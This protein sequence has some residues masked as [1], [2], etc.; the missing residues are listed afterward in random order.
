MAEL[1]QNFTVTI[2]GGLHARP[3]SELVGIAKSFHSKIEILRDGKV[4]N[5]KSPVKILLLGVR[6]GDSITVMIDG[7]DAA[8]AMARVST[9]FEA[10]DNEN[11]PPAAEGGAAAKPTAPITIEAAKAATP[12]HGIGASEGA[13]EGVAYHFFQSPL[14]DPSSLPALEVKGNSKEQELAR[15]RN[16]LARSS[17]EINARAK[18][19]DPTGA[20]I[21]A[22]LSEI[23]G[24]EEW[25]EQV[26]AHI[27]AGACALKAVLI[28]GEETARSVEALDDPYA[29]ARAEDIRAVMRII[30]FTLMG[31]EL[32][33]LDRVPYG[34][35]VVA[36]E[37]TALDLST[38]D[39]SRI[40]GLLCQKGASTSHAAIVSRAHGIPA[41]F[42]FEVSAAK[43]QRVSYVALDGSSGEVVLDPSEEVIARYRA[44]ID[45]ERQIA[46][47]RLA[48]KEVQPVT[49]DGREITIAANIGSL[50]EIKAAKENGA[51]GVGL[52]RTELLFMDR[53]EL[54]TEDEQLAIY[55]VALRAFEGQD[56]IIRT[57]DIGGD[58]PLRGVEFPAEENP[59]LGW[60]GIRMCLD[61]PSI[62][63]PQ[64]R[65]LLR[66][67]PAGKLKV[68]LPMVSD[69]E[70]VRATKQLI[71]ECI[72]E[73]DAEGKPY[74]RF[75]LGIMVETPAAVLAAELFAKE[76]AFFSIGTNDL[77]QYVMAADRMNPTVAKLY[78]TDNAAVLNAVS[79]VCLAAQSAGIWV[80]VCGE[81][82]ANPD[83]ARKFIERGVTELSMSPASI[84]RAKQVVCEL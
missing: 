61:T 8:D 5:A 17:D 81:A 73:L 72:M 84:L 82:A 34:A 38:A 44:S 7:D 68:M 13:A 24:D 1:Q 16:A 65:A 23:A 25:Q 62:F 60:R 43:L 59:F 33:S 80:G 30:A 71:D 56:V 26:T 35:I 50:G 47:Q 14:P 32:P 69:I 77:T 28:S 48:F 10:G 40:G 12:T 75:D 63:K 2:H 29:R 45:A 27:R 46:K 51:M 18:D 42:G 41:V 66:A 4:A 22:A 3:A 58:K 19:D 76:V 55:E 54:P 74:A 78:K 37:I 39:L 67:A 9:F 52:F 79:L 49:K 21:V 11:T 36:E 15:Y 57:L 83:L 64:L 53:R 70:E 6:E 31:K 20:E